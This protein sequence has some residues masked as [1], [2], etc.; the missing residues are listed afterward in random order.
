MMIRPPSWVL[1]ATT[2]SVM[3]GASAVAGQK[4]EDVLAKQ[5]NLTTFRDLVKVRR[6]QE[7][8]ASG[9]SEPAASSPAS[10]GALF[11]IYRGLRV[12]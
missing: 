6:K 4:L 2:L 5:A 8:T 3:L 12:A 1:W 11:D 9:L 10:A 7:S